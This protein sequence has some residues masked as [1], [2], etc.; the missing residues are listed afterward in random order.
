MEDLANIHKPISSLFSA[1][2]NF[3][4]TQ[5]QIQ[6]FEDNGYLTNLPCLNDEQ[7]ET[8]KKELQVLMKGEPEIQVKISWR[9]L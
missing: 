8:L 2:T 3:Q 6:F 4:L 7:I 9:N 1:S 5:E